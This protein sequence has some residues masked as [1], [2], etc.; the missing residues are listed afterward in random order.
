VLVLRWRGGA[1][2]LWELPEGLCVTGPAP[3]KLGLSVRRRDGDRYAVR[4]LWDR[5]TLAWEDV[6]KVELL[7]CCLGPLLAALGLDLW[8]MLDRQPARHKAWAA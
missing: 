2:R 4:L 3:G 8:A 7:G 6:S 1:E 5:T